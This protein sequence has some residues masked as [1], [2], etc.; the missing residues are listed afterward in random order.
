M[1]RAR[2]GQREAG[3]PPRGGVFRVCLKVDGQESAD[4]SRGAPPWGHAASPAPGFVQKKASGILIVVQKAL[5]N[6]ILSA[7]NIPL[8][9]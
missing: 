8:N 5:V 1:R 6:S 9:D 4:G 2:P 3:S 7:L